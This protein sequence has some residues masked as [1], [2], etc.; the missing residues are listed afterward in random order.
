MIDDRII[1]DKA[2]SGCLIPSMKLGRGVV[3]RTL[4]RVRSVWSRF[5]TRE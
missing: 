1:D 2:D 4:L 3:T 5:T